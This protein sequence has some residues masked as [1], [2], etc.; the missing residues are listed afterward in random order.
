MVVNKNRKVKKY[1]G[2]KTHGCGSMKKRR[3]AG[4]RG[5]RGNAGTGKR[6]DV[7]KPKIW[8]DKKYFGKYGFKKK[9][10]VEKINT[11]NI[12][13]VEQKLD[14]WV[15]KGKAVEKSG[16]FEIDL[17]ALGY[18]KL[19]SLGKVTKKMKIIV[20]YA[21][22]SAAEKLKSAGCELSVSKSKDKKEKP[23]SEQ[24]PEKTEK[25]D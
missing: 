10:M 21:S 8:K 18:N 6:C 15:K 3:G 25:K 11:I 16:V 24:K 17:G 9:G 22:K 14:S 13:D 4:N 1:R 12:F 5:G 19:L 20:S 7:N 2:S 23:K